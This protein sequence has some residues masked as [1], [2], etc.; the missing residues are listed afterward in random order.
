LL[1]VAERYPYGRAPFWLLVIAVVAVVLRI[2]TARQSEQ[3][4]DLVLACFTEAHVEAYRKVLPE[5]ER[6]HGVKVQLQFT[7]W[8]SMQA[9]LQN[10]LLAGTDT[11]DLAE[12]F[13]G[14]LG[15]F[16][17]GPVEDFG[18]MDLTD[19]LNADGLHDRLVQSRFSLWQSRGRIYALPHD[20][21][22][23]MLAYRKDLLDS[24]GVDPSQLDT[25]DKFVQVGRRLSKDLNG[26]GILDRYMI[27]FRYDGNWGLSTLMLQR[28]GQFFTPDG[29]VAF[30]TEDNAEL[31]RWYILQTRGPQ[32]IGYEAGWGQALAKAVLDGLVLFVITP[33]WRTHIFQDEIPS[34]AGKMALMPLPAWTPGGRR[35]SVWGG[36]GL[37]I[38]KR[39]KHP[40][41]A[42]ELAK[43]L[44]FRREGLGERFRATNILPAL[45]DAWTLPE[46]GEPNPY[47]RNEA[48]GKTYAALAPETPPLYSSPIDQIG[49]LKVDQAYNRSATY[50]EKNGE[51]GLLEFIRKQLAQSAEEVRILAAREKTLAEQAK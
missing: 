48:I 5:F 26:D 46:I 35:T 2:A 9:R 40:D 36:T 3:R 43:F 32:K 19:R 47:W 38:A 6:I 22:P 10:A 39:T 1:R 49:R 42:W 51:A 8:A 27:D 29:D 12:L 4:P 45:K 25:W 50:Y 15:F 37:I 13:E 41:L 17:R 44:Y 11:P 31:I 33:D 24:L 16:T 18:V 7:N 28:G 20:V 23:V 14:A 30:A 34:L 21:H